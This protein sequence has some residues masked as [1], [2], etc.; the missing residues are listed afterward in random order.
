MVRPAFGA[1]P[2][3]VP[4][5]LG[6][7]Q[8]DTAQLEGHQAADRVDVEVLVELDV[9][10]LAEVL[11]G[12]PRRHP[13]MLVAQVFHGRDFVGVVLVGDLADDLLQHVLDRDQAR[14]GAVLVD[15]QHHVDAVA[16][17]LAQQRVERFGVG[18]E[19]RWRASPSDTS[20]SRPPL[21][22]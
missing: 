7:R 14:D 4:R 21:V 10:Q 16:L 22:E 3:P 20:V 13:E 5:H 15:Q 12:Q 11:D 2:Q 19:H 9:V 17:H 18:D 8:R 1:Q 6:A